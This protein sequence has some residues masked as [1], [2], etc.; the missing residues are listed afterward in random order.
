MTSGTGYH[1]EVMPNVSIE[2]PCFV[3]ITFHK[4][5]KSDWAI[6]GSETQA[7]AFNLFMPAYWI[8]EGDSMTSDFDACVL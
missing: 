6:V 7:T 4:L 3:V 8:L 5:R 2:N 1:S